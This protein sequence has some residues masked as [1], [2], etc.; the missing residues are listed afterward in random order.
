[1]K[2][3]NRLHTQTQTHTYDTQQSK[4]KESKVRFELLKD[5]RTLRSEMQDEKT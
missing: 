3:S 4:E 5:G 1:M 2:V